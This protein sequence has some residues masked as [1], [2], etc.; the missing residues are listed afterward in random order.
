MPAIRLPILYKGLILL[1]V[2]LLFEIVIAAALLYLQQYYG[3]AVKAE[4]HRKQLIFHANEFWQN[5][6][7]MTTARIS[8]TF[9]SGY[10]HDLQPAQRAMEQYKIL[11]NLT[12]ADS[13]QHQ[14]LQR[15]MD[16]HE[17]SANLCG[18]LRPYWSGSGGVLGQLQALKHNLR[19]FNGL[20]KAQIDAGAAIRSFRQNEL[21]QSV[22]AAQKVQLIGMLMQLV[23]AFAEVGSMVIAYLLFRYF[24]RGIHG[25]VQALM[26][27]IQ[28]FKTGAELNP[29]IT[30]N[31]ELAL[32]DARFHEMAA[33]V[34]AAQRIK[35][36]FLNTMSDELRTPINSARACLARLSQNP[37]D[38][39]EDV[40][41]IVLDA[42]ETLDRLIVLVDD[43]LA[44]QSPGKS[45]LEIMPRDIE[46]APIIQK[47]IKSLSAFAGQHGVL[48]EREGT[49]LTAYADPHR[50]VQ[51]LVNLLSN[52]IK[53]SPEGSSV[54]VS[55]AAID[56]QVEIRVKDSGRGVPAH[57]RDAIFERFEQVSAADATEKA[58]SGLG[59][60]ICREIIERH[61]GTIGVNSEEGK[62]STFWFR[63]PVK[64]EDQESNC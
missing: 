36:A 44:L 33:E 10:G 26:S 21:R 14:L 17:Q 16:L 30:G 8:G 31:D 48:L 35:Q 60:P 7:Q 46:L 2:P 25:G 56:G 13:Q 12:S 63:L 53:F 22:K 6:M 49:Q 57:M 23:V 20:V 19:I 40:K 11:W 27:N 29:A 34:A 64:L 62:G 24:M 38:V 47:S 55:A 58:G 59:L 37:Q 43:L 28:A 52:A 4:A 51:V 3:D 61:G 18:E 54:V 32:L 9:L 5:S 50:I 15:V 39:P 42:E 45:R 41:P 1:C